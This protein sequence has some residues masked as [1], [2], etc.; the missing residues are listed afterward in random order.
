VAVTA[1]ATE[2]TTRTTAAAI[3]T[4]TVTEVIAITTAA[5]TVTVLTLA[6]W[7]L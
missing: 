7:H 6:S 5:S 2:V 1:T 4:A 3:V